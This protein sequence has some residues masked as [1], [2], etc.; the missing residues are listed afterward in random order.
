MKKINII[1][2]S[3]FLFE[4]Q[5]FRKVTMDDI[6]TSCKISKKTLYKH[7]SNKELV[8]KAYLEYIF[9]K[10]NKNLNGIS[11]LKIDVIKE[12]IAFDRVN[13]SLVMR[14]HHNFIQELAFNYPNAAIMRVEFKDIIQTKL[15]KL[16]LRGQNQGIIRADILAVT[17]SS[18]RVTQLELCFES[19][20]KDFYRNEYDTIFALYLSSIKSR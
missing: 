16:L 14:L 1:E 8:I 13:K 3:A 11:N 17:L 12:L 18:F 19:N 15:E 10:L 6:S 4:K 7:F 2:I 20:I 5:G 9:S